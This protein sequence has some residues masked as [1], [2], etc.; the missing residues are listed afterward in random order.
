MA[1]DIQSN[2]VY[3]TGNNHT[4]FK[5]KIYQQLKRVQQLLK[6]REERIVKAQK[7]TCQCAFSMFVNLTVFGRAWQKL[8]FTIILIALEGNVKNCSGVSLNW[9]NET[10]QKET[11]TSFHRFKEESLRR[12]VCLCMLGQPG[13]CFFLKSKTRS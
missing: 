5:I 4:W 6:T 7:K 3:W 10:Q 13:L 2:Q 1:T 11:E 8:I 12:K 9:N